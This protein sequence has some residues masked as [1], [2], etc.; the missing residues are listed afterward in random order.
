MHVIIPNTK[1]THTMSNYI[2]I[3]QKQRSNLVLFNY[4]FHIMFIKIHTKYKLK[5]I[6]KLYT[7]NSA[8]K[9]AMVAFINTV[10]KYILSI[11]ANF[12]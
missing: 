11:P 9:R 7:P 10:F 2:N 1:Y 6:Y 8:K 4:C 3:I 5:I 12:K